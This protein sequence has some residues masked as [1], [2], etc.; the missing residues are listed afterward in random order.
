MAHQILEHIRWL[1]HAG[2]TIQDREKTIVIDPFQTDFNTPADLILITHAHYDH[3]SPED[4]ARVQSERSVIVTEPQSAKKLSGNVRVVAPGDKLEAAGIPLEVVPAYN[5]NKTF[6]PKANQWLGFI[7]TAAGKRIYHTGD[8]DLI[9]EMAKLKADVV[10]LPVSGTYVM[11]ADEAVQAIKQIKPEL[12]IPMH[13]DTLVGSREDA[14][15]FQ[16]ALAGVCQVALLD[17]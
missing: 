6:H 12:A 14:E 8:S 10:L 1:G 11:T 17:S 4:I 15:K 13:Y 9:P 16:K 7:L 2:F 3:C 5:T